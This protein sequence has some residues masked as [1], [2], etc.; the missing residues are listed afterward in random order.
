M[1]KLN[2][3]VLIQQLEALGDQLGA[4]W[5][6]TRNYDHLKRLDTM[7]VKVVLLIQGLKAVEGREV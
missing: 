4:L 7:I 6:D 1:P 2:I 5:D 3:A